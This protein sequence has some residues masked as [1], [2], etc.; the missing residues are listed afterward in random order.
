MAAGPSTFAKTGMLGAVF[1]ASAFSCTG[2]YVQLH[3]GDPGSAGTSNTIANVSGNIAS[4]SGRVTY[5]STVA[6]STVSS[7]AIMAWNA[8]GGAAV[9]WCSVW[10][11]SAAG[12]HLWNVQLS[13]SGT[14]SSGQT[15]RIYT[16]DLSFTVS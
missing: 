4:S 16:G 15:V 10:D 6:T 1:N 7:S 11:A 3:S 13:S 12:Q 5:P 8:C 9:S 14:Y 2:A